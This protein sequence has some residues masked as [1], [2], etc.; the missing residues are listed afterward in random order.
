MDDFVIGGKY[1]GYVFMGCALGRFDAENDKGEMEK[2]D[3]FNMYVI[4]PVSS[5]KS[6]DYSAS[7]F[8]AEKKRCIS[9][10]VWEGLKPGDRVKLFFDDKKRVV[11]A[12]L[13]E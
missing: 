4:S 5:Y 9:P 1:E 11:M 7:G 13:D 6:D 10:D 12:V 3:Y 8:K 2:R